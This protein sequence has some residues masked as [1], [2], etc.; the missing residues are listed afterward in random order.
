MM[1]AQQCE[2]IGLAKKFVLFFFSYTGSSSV[3][4]SL[5]SFETTLL[6][7]IVTAVISACIFKNFSKLVNFLCSHFNIEDGRK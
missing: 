1:V 7:C 5:A 6:D 2:T 3:S 4:L